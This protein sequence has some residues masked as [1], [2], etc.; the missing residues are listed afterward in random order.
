MDRHIGIVIG[1]D[2]A[3]AGVALTRQGTLLSVDAA[4]LYPAGRIFSP[5]ELEQALH[6][7]R[8]D[9]IA[10][11]VWYEHVVI[12]DMQIPT[13]LSAEEAM[14]VIRYQLGSQVPLPE[15]EVVCHARRVSSG[16]QRVRVA[17]IPR[18]D[19]ETPLARLAGAGIEADLLTSPLLAGDAG[20]ADGAW[21]VPEFEAEFMFGPGGIM[22]ARGTQP[23]WTEEMR[24]LLAQAMS[25]KSGS[26][27][28]TLL[29]AAIQMA[30][31]S[32]NGAELL[33]ESVTEGLPPELRPKRHIWAKRAVII[34]IFVCFAFFAGM[35]A[36]IW[37]TSSI[38]GKAARAFSAEVESRLLR[39]NNE[40]AM[41]KHA[42]DLSDEG[43]KALGKPNRIF[44]LLSRLGICLPQDIYIESIRASND[45]SIQ[46]VIRGASDEKEFRDQLSSLS[47]FVIT[48]LTNETGRDGVVYRVTMQVKDD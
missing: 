33:M 36:Q 8:A 39:V 37:K 9:R 1:Q 46:L 26:G 40:T 42:C 24:G 47:Q 48:A 12:I 35:I 23:V 41:I 4:F 22:L 10:I 15:T 17:A 25:Q 31:M 20:I 14:G 32:L 21:C 16:E 3:A 27:R 2:G 28:E 19:W 29:P 45:G 5:S 43:L 38:N 6:A 44:T 34:L 13:E 18:S 11:G 30:M 7:E